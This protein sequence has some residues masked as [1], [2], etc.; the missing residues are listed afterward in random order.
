MEVRNADNTVATANGE[1]LWIKLRSRFSEAARQIQHRLQDERFAQMQAGLKVTTSSA[2]ME[3][4]AL[5]TLVAC[6]VDWNLTN[7]AG[8][9][10]PFNSSNARKLYAEPKLVFIRQQ[11]DRFIGENANFIGA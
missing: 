6:T 10:I 3:Q 7:S 1:P 11:V 9:P 2:Q 4:D 8:E 5:D